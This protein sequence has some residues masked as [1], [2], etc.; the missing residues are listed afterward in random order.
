MFDCSFSYF[1]GSF[2]VAEVASRFTDV[3]AFVAA[4]KKV[5]FKLVEKVY[6]TPFL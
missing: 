3:D 6:T 5:G 4:I 2:K 1:S